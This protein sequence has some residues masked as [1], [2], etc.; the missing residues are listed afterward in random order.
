MTNPLLRRA[1]LALLPLLAATAAHA[2]ARHLET[3]ATTLAIDSPCA[4]E[5]TIQP[6]PTLTGR[7]TIDATATHP[8][9]TAQLVLD[10][11]TAAKLHRQAKS[12]WEPDRESDFESTM[13]MTIRI[14]AAM[15]L[16]IEESGGAQYTLGAL[17]GPLTLSISGG[18]K[19]HAESAASL[20]I[21]LS[22]GATIGIGQLDGTAHA[23]LSG[24]GTLRI[25]HATLQDLTLSM[26]GGGVFT[27]G[28]GSTARA[29]IDLSGAASVQVGGTT[30][31]ATVD[32]SGVGSVHFAK[33]TGK[34]TK[35]VSGM[36]TVSAD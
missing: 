8:E 26:S 23:E 21:D 22:G 31:D 28:D 10:A 7:V 1:A 35:D 30:G 29:T 16:T 32:L 36:G 12:C 24:G 34:L 33:V 3:S 4:R 18:V 20:T 13:A 6:D 25:D 2:Q 9:E 17:H 5:V 15:P 19:L 11:G 14:P 27:L